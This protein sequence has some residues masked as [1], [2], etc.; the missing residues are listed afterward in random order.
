MELF[1]NYNTISGALEAKDVPGVHVLSYKKMCE[2][3]EKK[4]KLCSYDALISK[5]LL[6]FNIIG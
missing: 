3:C 5:L 4:K 2:L 6:F 1:S